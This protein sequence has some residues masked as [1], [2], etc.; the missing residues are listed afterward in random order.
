MARI[1]KNNDSVNVT[2]TYSNTDVCIIRIT[3]DKLVNILT[4]HIGRLKKSKEWFAS[5]TFSASMLLVLLTSKFENKWSLSG[6][7][8]QMFFILLFILSV[9][10]FLYSI[11]NCFRHNI[12]VHTIVEEIKSTEQR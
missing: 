9:F 10:Y 2:N 1:G 8:W 5:L 6:E 12:T 4:I 7:Q 11:F 3:E